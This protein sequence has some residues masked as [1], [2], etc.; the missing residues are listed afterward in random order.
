MF[1]GYF[2]KLVLQ[3]HG[4]KPKLQSNK[5]NGVKIVI[6]GE[7][8]LRNRSEGFAGKVT[9]PLVSRSGDEGLTHI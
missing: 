7:F 1:T 3:T 8:P 6:S 4:Y 5:A 9:D 2:F